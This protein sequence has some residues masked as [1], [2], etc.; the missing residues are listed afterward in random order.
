LNASTHKSVP[1][2]G[3]EHRNNIRESSYQPPHEFLLFAQALFH[4]FALR[5]I[6][7]RTL[8]AHE[9]A[10]GVA[11]GHARIAHVQQRAVLPPQR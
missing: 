11:N 6:R 9:F 2:G 1:S 3:I 5:H 4:F 10:L 8:K 7:E